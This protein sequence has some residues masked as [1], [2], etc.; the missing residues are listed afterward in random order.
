MVG[1]IGVYFY[2]I[3]F[4]GQFNL[5]VAAVAHAANYYLSKRTNAGR[6]KNHFRLP[7]LRE[8]EAPEHIKRLWLDESAVS[9]DVQ[10]TLMGWI[11]ILNDWCWET[12]WWKEER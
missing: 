10:L 6:K 3:Y 8:V 12:A 11:S 1:Q 2:E 5:S 9:G 4:R 7:H